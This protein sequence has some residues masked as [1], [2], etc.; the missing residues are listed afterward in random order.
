MPRRK[1][2]DNDD[3]P[4]PK[5]KKR[6]RKKDDE[7]SVSE[8]SVPSQPVVFAHKYIDELFGCNGKVLGTIPKLLRVAVCQGIQSINSG[9]SSWRPQMSLQST[10]RRGVQTDHHVTRLFNK[11]TVD[12]NPIKF[13]T[14]PK[15]GLLKI[16]SL[17]SHF[18]F[19][20]P[21]EEI[22]KF[23]HD[24]LLYVS[25]MLL[26]EYKPISTQINVEHDIARDKEGR[27]LRTQLDHLWYHPKSN[28][29]VL[30][31][32]KCQYRVGMEKYDS[33]V[34]GF[35]KSKMFTRR[36]DNCAMTRYDLHQAQCALGHVMFQENPVLMTGI[37]KLKSMVVV[38]NGKNVF[39]FAL[40]IGHEQAARRLL[41][42]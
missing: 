31:E 19:H 32:L 24:S 12:K 16:Q 28:T 1:R 30:V 15:D 22:K 35:D 20:Y 37:Q 34:V 18:H 38:V 25:Q 39:F 23:T 40:H 4:K 5:A 10:Q 36:K 14:I 41:L 3:D 42:G 11:E 21:L 33:E 6:R 9:G 7:E 29:H 13:C 17:I 2:D 26:K 8:A 27:K